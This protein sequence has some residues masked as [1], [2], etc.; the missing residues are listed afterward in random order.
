M[1]DGGAVTA[2]VWTYIVATYTNVGASPKPVIWVNGMDH[3]IGAPPYAGLAA[4]GSLSFGCLD[5]MT[6]GVDN[7]SNFAGS[8]DELAIYEHVLPSGQIVSHYMLG[9]QSLAP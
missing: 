6:T 5:L 4:G 3:A 2:N 7:S 1:F 9:L 8:I